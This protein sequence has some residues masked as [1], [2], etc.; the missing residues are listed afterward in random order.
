M[1]ELC[2]CARTHAH[3]ND[4]P[5]VWDGGVGLKQTKRKRTEENETNLWFSHGMEADGH[6]CLSCPATCTRARVSVQVRG[7]AAA[8][9][10]AHCRARGTAHFL[11]ICSPKK[12][13]LPSFLLFLCVCF[14][15][16]SL[17]RSRTPGGLDLRLILTRRVVH[18]VMR[19]L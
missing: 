6:A 11:K 4:A 15:T 12:V 10:H 5:P 13:F 3:G 1:P 17:R 19:Q 8:D 18:S 2:A 16:W 9:V 14:L 7:A